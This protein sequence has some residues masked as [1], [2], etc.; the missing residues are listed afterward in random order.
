VLDPFCGGG[1]IP[2]EAQRLGLRAYGS[3]LTPV[4]VLIT[5]A[6]IELPP[7][8]AGQ[9]PVNP[10]DRAGM[11]RSVNWPGAS[12]LAADVRYYGQWMRDEAERRIGHLYPKVALPK[13]YGGG[14]AT[15][16]AWLWARTVACPNPACGAQMPLVR[17]F[18]LSTKKGKEAWVEPQVDRAAK[19]VR[20]EV[21]T[22]SGKVPDGTVNRGGAGCLVCGTSV[23]FDHVRAEGRAGRMGQQLMAIV[24]EG[25][26]ARVYLD[27]TDKQEAKAKEAVPEWAPDTELPEKALSFRV[28]L[29]G[30]THHR[31]LFTPANSSR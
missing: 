6:L 31:D 2:L 21:R 3:D 24:A 13:E 7:Q 9:P 10:Q 25:Q 11:A 17:S 20:F 15:V 23:P 28:Q 1:S 8:F 26:R 27:P 5:K 4:A 22:G 29:Y 12:G 16:I 14:E 30:M 18:A 19:T